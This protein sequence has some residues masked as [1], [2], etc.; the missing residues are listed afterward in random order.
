MTRLQITPL[1]QD[2]MADI[3]EYSL[4]NFGAMAARLYLDG[5][6]EAFAKIVKRPS[7]GAPEGRFGDGVRRY[8]YKSHRIYYRDDRAGLM[9]IRILH[10][11]RDAQRAFEKQ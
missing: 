11:A 7:I 3:R 1:A 5:I 4:T 8:T 9:I 10:H 6:G 2:D